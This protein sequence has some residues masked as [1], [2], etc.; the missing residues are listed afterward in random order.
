LPPTKKLPCLAMVRGPS[1]VVG[2]CAAFAVLMGVRA[3]V[4]SRAGDPM[5]PPDLGPILI[6]PFFAGALAGYVYWRL[7]QCR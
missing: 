3:F 7:A 5:G 2:A 6:V 1:I 4:F